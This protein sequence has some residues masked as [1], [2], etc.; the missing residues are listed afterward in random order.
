VIVGK[1]WNEVVETE[2][3]K[4][5]EM[6]VVWRKIVSGYLTYKVGITDRREGT[7]CEKNTH[8][9]DRTNDDFSTLRDS[10]RE[11]SIPTK[12]SVGKK[13]QIRFGFSSLDRVSP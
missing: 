7:L 11:P 8:R 9:D 3:L 2:L 13:A 12:T 5:S 1:E 6:T 10:T 4:P